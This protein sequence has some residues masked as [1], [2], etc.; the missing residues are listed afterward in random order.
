MSGL[1][2]VQ[3]YLD[4]ILITGKDEKHLQNLESS[5]KRLKDYEFVRTNVHS[6]NRFNTSVT[7]GVMGLHKA[8]S[9]V[10]AILDATAPQ[11]LYPELGN[12][13]EVTAS[14]ALSGQNMKMDRTM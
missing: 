14:V 11:I 9:K 5:L 2:G 7:S 12:K 6:S 3:C 1:P 10:K 13:A 8:P 4:D